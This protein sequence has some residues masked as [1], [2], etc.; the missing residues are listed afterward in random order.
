MK[1][2][3]NDDHSVTVTV[4]ERTITMS[5]STVSTVGAVITFVVVFVGWMI[6]RMVYG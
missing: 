2:T 5:F 1:I 6:F 3:S 4:F